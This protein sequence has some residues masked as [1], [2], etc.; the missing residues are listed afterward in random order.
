VRA[1]P[2][3]FLAHETSPS[4]LEPHTRAIRTRSSQG[5]IVLSLSNQNAARLLLDAVNKLFGTSAERLGAVQR[6][7]EKDKEFFAALYDEQPSVRLAL[8]SAL[9]LL[10]CQD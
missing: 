2:P 7:E 6:S 10:R 3:L 5:N 8:S 1:C 4:D 9:C